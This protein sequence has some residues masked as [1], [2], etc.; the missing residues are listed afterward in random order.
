MKICDNHWKML[1]ECIDSRG[2]GHL[3]SKDTPQLLAKL[4]NDDGHTASN[5]DPLWRAMGM[6][7]ARAIDIGGIDLLYNNQD[8]SEKCPVCEAIIHTK[9]KDIKQ[10]MPATKEDVEKY[11]IEEPVDCC[12]EVCKER[13]MIATS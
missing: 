12:L 8:G 1:R 2:L 5:Y 11:W 3:V 7:Y 10:T 4:Q 6:I 13:G 9:F